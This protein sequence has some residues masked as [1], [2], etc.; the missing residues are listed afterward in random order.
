MAPPIHLVGRGGDMESTCC[1]DATVELR[2]TD[3]SALGWRWVR[4]ELTA[5][6]PVM[7]WA[8]IAELPYLRVR[9]RMSRHDV[10]VVGYDDERQIAY[11]VDNDR[12]DVQEV[13]CAALARAR[14][15]TGFP[16][17]TRHATFAVEWP[18][19]SRI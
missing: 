10:V 8:D 15:S 17:S 19:G 6:R 16:A 4:D 5:G 13:P 12:E 2:R 1:L 3:N 14:R 9:L 18:S 11:V 7:V